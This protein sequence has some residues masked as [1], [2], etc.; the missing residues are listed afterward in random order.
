MRK[1]GYKGGNVWKLIYHLECV[2]IHDIAILPMSKLYSCISEKRS[3]GGRIVAFFTDFNYHLF[4]VMAKDKSS[5]LYLAIFSLSGVSEYPALTKHFPEFELFER[6]FFENSQIKPVGHPWLKPV[7]KHDIPYPFFEV[8]S[9]SSHEVGVGPVHAGIIEPGYF[10]FSCM[11]EKILHLEIQLGYQHRG[12]EKKIIEKNRN[13][14]HRFIEP[15]MEN[16]VSDSPLGHTLAYTQAMES[17]FGVIKSK[18]STL[19]STIALELERICAHL[20]NIGDILG[21]VGYYV[22][23]DAF[24]A[25]KT[26]ILNTL[27]L[28]SGSRFGKGLLCVGGVNY[29]LTAEKIQK[30]GETL[31]AV[32]CDVE[33]FMRES[34][35]ENASV[36]SRLEGT[37]VV[38]T[39]EA[40]TLGLVGQ[41][42]RSCGVDLDIREDFPSLEYKMF[43]I[44]NTL[45]YNG[46]VFDRTY[47]RYS[48]ILHSIEWILER[49]ESIS[50]QKRDESISMISTSAKANQFIISMVEGWRGEI[51]HVVVTDSSGEIMS[52]KIKDPSFN[53]WRALTLAVKEEGISDF[54][55]CNK[56]FNLSYA[57][58]DL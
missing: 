56:S 6:E 52:Y 7:R 22:G 14:T 24:I 17:L 31:R 54:P 13:S 9:E 32:K 58:H 5:L 49:V 39:Q 46:D 51:V 40:V 35:L 8:E 55:L 16:I 44:H 1:T 37:G 12:V 41:S 30:M 3:D 23:K 10:R 18:S 48:E 21:D 34:I 4:V 15:I 2:D 47:I 45:L 19:L 43:P 57:G 25:Q 27:L 29:E 33:H 53:N 38:T 28:L 36:I 42:A 50:P 11:G 26:K 20:G